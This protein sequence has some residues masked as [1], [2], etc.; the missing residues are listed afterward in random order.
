MKELIKHLEDLKLLTTDAQ[1]Y[2]ADEIWDRLLVLILELYNQ[3]RRSTD[4]L[5]RLQSIELQDI[6]TKY[7]EYN[8]PSLQVKVMEFTKTLNACTEL[9][10][11]R[12]WSEEN[13]FDIKPMVEIIVHESDQEVLE[14][15]IDL[16]LEVCHNIDDENAQNHIL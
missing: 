16:F 10:S 8:R 5:Q 13:G 9:L 4:A 11:Y 14:L 7:L 1:L 15:A 2:K 3:N 12:R 6:I